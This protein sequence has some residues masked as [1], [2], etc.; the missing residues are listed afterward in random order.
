VTVKHYIVFIGA[1]APLATELESIKTRIANVHIVAPAAKKKLAGVTK[2]AIDLALKSLFEE[3]TR[4]SSPTKLAWLSL[5]MYEPTYPEQ[6]TQVW[7][8]FGHAAWVETVPNSLLHK[9]RPTK[10]HIQKRINEIRPL[11]HEVSNAA[12][13]QRK[14][15]PLALPL[16]NFSSS[17]TTDLKRYWYNDLTKAEIARKIKAFKMRYSQ[18]K[19]KAEGGF[20]DDK[21]LI[22]KPAKDT[23]CHGLAHPLGSEYKSFACGKFRYGVALFPG[24]HYDVSSRKTATIQCQLKT[25][26]GGIRFVRGENRTHINIFSNDH[27]LPDK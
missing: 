7:T 21:N 17:I 12:Y 2:V 13:S 23:E 5:W 9:V 14:T 15:S 19:D 20:T 4:D 8:A 3:L 25:S 22:F 10:E 1:T 6:F 18:V 11:L 27:L 26:S 24:F 16:R